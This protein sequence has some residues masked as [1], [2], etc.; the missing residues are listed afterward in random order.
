MVQKTI[1]DSIEETQTIFREKD[2]FKV[3]FIPETIKYR[4]NQR[5]KIIYNL[6]ENLDAHKRPYHM[7]LKGNYGTGKTVTIN[8]IFS[9]VE[10]RYSKVKTVH[11]NCKNHRSQYE[12][13]LKVYEKIFNEN[14]DVAGLST[15]NILN[16]IIREIVKKNIILL[17]ALDDISSVKSDRDLNNVLY[18]LLRAS[19]T[20]I[21]ARICVFSLTNEKIITFLDDNVRT[22]FSGIEIDFPNY[23]YKEIYNILSERCQLGLY[24]GAISKDIIRNVAKFAFDFGDLRKA[25]DEIYK[26]GYNAEYEGCHKIL[27]RHFH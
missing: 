12:I 25:F 7:I 17:V 2:V 23:T 20:N 3:E 1:W 6:K 22:I 24:K 5:D 26:A 21:D 11:I 16:K 13:Y 19:E 8:H 15:F 27:K 18:N 9:K 4:D 14:M 10:K